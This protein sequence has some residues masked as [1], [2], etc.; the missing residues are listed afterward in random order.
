MKKILILFPIIIL[1][2]SCENKDLVI[3]KSQKN[4]SCSDII[5]KALEKKTDDLIRE[6]RNKNTGEWLIPVSMASINDCD[7]P[8]DYYKQEINAEVFSQTKTLVLK[9]NSETKVYEVLIQIN[10]N[11]K[12]RYE[13]Y[14]IQPTE[15]ITLG[16]DSNFD[17][18]FNY[19]NNALEGLKL[20]NLSKIKILYK[21]HK[22][23]LISKY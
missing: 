15:V 5:N 13:K 6:W 17:I 23:K 1:M 11:N 3:L 4:C 22:I 2:F 7:P 8:F 18:N 16:C 21:I 14:N 9:N 12:I 20:S 19:S 10:E